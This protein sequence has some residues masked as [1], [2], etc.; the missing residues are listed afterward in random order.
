MKALVAINPKSGGGKGAVVG[1]KVRNLLADSTHRIS[2]VEAHSRESS[3]HDVRHA[4][5]GEKFEVLIAVGGDVSSTT[6]SHFCWSSKCLCSSSLPEREMT[7]HDH[8]EHLE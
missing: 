3:L 5:K 7:S 4:L 2:F 8:L 1:A 6:S